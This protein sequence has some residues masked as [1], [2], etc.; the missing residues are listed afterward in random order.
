MK[1]ELQDEILATEIAKQPGLLHQILAER[2][3]Q[4]NQSTGGAVTGM[5]MGG[6]NGQPAPI[7]NDED[8]AAGVPPAAGV[9]S[10]NSPQGAIAGAAARAGGVA[11]A[12]K[13]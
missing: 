11:V 2:V 3:A 1:E 7:T 10:P 6:I 4:M 5:G 13:K 9:S 12:P 8:S